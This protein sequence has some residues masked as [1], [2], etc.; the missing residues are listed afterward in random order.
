MLFRKKSKKPDLPLVPGRDRASVRSETAP[1]YSYYARRSTEPRTV[2][3][4]RGPTNRGD[5]SSGVPVRRSRFQHVVIVVCVIIGLFCVGKLLFLVPHSKVVVTGNGQNQQLSTARYAT[6]ADKLL[7]SSV[8]NATKLTLNTNGIAHELEQDFPELS[9]VVVAAPL[10]GNR[11][12][13]YVSPTRPAFELET[14]TGHYTV[15]SKGYVLSRLTA[16]VASN[17]VR[18]REA[19]TRPISPGQQYFAGSTMNFA[20]TVSYQLQKAG[21]TV[22]YLDLP[23]SSPYELV[24][25]LTGK[26]YHIRFNLQADAMQ[27]SGGAIATLAQLGGNAPTSYLDMR[28][29]GRAAYK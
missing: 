11:P 21:Y 12:V 18:L 29:P 20:A 27:Q 19:T 7:R 3:T 6:A 25:Y 10:V 16:P 5:T 28:T 9:S 22:D 26:P 14:A 17:I 13:I 8:L 15:D 24:A 23:A 2:T 4:S 1:V